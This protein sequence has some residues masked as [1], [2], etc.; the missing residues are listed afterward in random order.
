MLLPYLDYAEVVFDGAL[1]K[2]ISKLQKVQDKCLKVRL[3][4]DRR[5][6]TDAIH[7]LANVSFLK[8]RREA[9]NVMLNFM[10]TRKSKVHLLNNREIRTRAHDAPLF[11][12]SIPR[13]EAYRRSVGYR[14]ATKWNSLTPAIRHT[15][16]YL[17]FKKL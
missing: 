8:D 16:T 14:G 11:E 4:K 7:K 9:H 10:F 5:Y 13:C 15:A 17:A 6:S 2:D 1:N 12:T 3:G